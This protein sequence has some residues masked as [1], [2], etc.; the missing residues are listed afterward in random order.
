MYNKTFSKN[1]IK[2]LMNLKCITA[3]LWLIAVINL[4]NIYDVKAQSKFM[5]IIIE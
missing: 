5:I 4:N 1:F 3:C 2:F